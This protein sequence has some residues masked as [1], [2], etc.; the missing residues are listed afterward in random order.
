MYKIGVISPY[1]HFTESIKKIASQIKMPVTVREG[2]L[3]RGLYYAN[4]LIKED[5]VNIIVARGPTA[6]LIEK[7]VSV[8]VIKINVTNF[9]ILKACQLAKHYSDQIVFIDH[10][11]NERKYDLS[12]ISETQE[13]SIALKQYENEKGINRHIEQ[14]ALTS[15]S[16]PVIVGTA[17]CLARNA[18]SQGVQSFVIH[19]SYE[20]ISEALHRAMETVV[21]YE[22]EKLRQK[23]LET[24][25]S[26]AFDGVIATD[27]EGK[28]SVFNEVASSISSI[29]SKDVIGKELSKFNYPFLKKMLGDGKASTK[30]VITYGKNK[31]MVNRI[32]IKNS[33]QSLVITFQE[34]TKVLQIDSQLRSELHTRRFYAKYTFEDIVYES[35]QMKDTIELAQKYSRA[36]STIL[37]HGESGT[38]KELLAQSIHNAS[39]RKNGPF[40]AINCAALPENLLESELFGYEEGAFTGAKKGGKP[41][42]FEMAHEG[43]LFL[44]EIGDLPLSLQARLLR[45]LQ[46]QEVMRIGGEKIIPVNVRIVSA[47][48]KNLREGAEKNSF[49]QDLYYRLNILQIK[50]P[51]L[52]DRKEDIVPLVQEMLSKRNI[53]F[54]QIDQQ[55][56]YILETHDW[57]G[58]VRELENVV[59]RM[60][61]YGETIPHDK[62]KQII[63]QDQRMNVTGNNLSVELGSLKDIEN[64]VILQ[65]Y[66]QCNGNKQ[67][68]SERLGISRT[69]LWKKL[70][71]LDIMV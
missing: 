41:G 51:P 44:D 48:N 3:Q 10:L 36:D 46:E 11:E 56:A 15:D 35:E 30:K 8:P 29:K 67:L 70:K 43:T 54:I 20:V 40:I 32:P 71:E 23:H 69:T 33:P 26:Y 25:I 24:I 4:K 7:K 22:K 58:N 16:K 65:L 9:D 28:V 31:Y 62:F 1:P 18:L 53:D 19:S 12:F 61:A 38:G 13:L 21:L 64:Q 37:I 50:T 49:R 17:E 39:S 45:V 68:L 55:L 14:I 57:P 59:E 34:T 6:D 47:T 5:H 2:A 63:F 52:R 66:E 27:R 42:L 60:V